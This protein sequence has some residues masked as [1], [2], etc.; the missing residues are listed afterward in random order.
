MSE[1][2]AILG[3]YLLGSIPTAYLVT[4]WK[5][6]GD[7]RRMG[8]GNIGGLNT[9]R[10]VGAFWG[11]FVAITDLVKAAAAVSI[12]YFLLSVSYEW[13]LG[14][15]LA[16]VVGHNWMV[17]LRF[18]GGKG[19]ASAIGVTL[20]LFSFYGYAWPP[21]VF[22]AIIAVPLIISRN[23]ALSAGISLFALPI[24]TWFATYNGF[25]T[26]AAVLLLLLIGFKFLPTALAAL[27]NTKGTR[28]FLFDNWR[29][30]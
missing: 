4:R 7:I 16:A 15:G 10:E 1:F 25:A 12:A 30:Q 24:I 29:R 5:T 26:L 22:A 21:V 14:A 3:A 13:V 2:L 27:K 17:W 11:L 18:S 8:G 19:M 23:V 9:F 20:A 6:G 28:D